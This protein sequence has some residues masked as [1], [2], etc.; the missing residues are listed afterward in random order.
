MGKGIRERDWGKRCMEGTVGKRTQGWDWT[1]G[2]TKTGCRESGTVGKG[3]SKVVPQ[4][5]TKLK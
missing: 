4:T 1:V 3:I 5:G 2:G